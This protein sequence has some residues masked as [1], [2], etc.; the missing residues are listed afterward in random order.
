MIDMG[1]NRPRPS[2]IDITKGSDGDS[3]MS[4]M[5]SMKILTDPAAYS[6]DKLV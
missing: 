2:N 3:V 6:K 1:K 4:N 5:T